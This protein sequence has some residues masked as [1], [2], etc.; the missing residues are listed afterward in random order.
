M[1]SGFSS[2]ARRRFPNRGFS[3]QHRDDR[4][5]NWHRGAVGPLPD[6]AEDAA[7][8]ADDPEGAR[9]TVRQT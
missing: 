9:H 1:A 4:T 8:E 5:P 7:D 3:E 6:V 2:G